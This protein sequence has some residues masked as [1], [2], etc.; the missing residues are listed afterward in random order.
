MNL[1]R[2]PLEFPASAAALLHSCCVVCI[3]CRLTECFDAVSQVLAGL[4]TGKQAYKDCL[5]NGGGKAGCRHT[6]KGY[7]TVN[8]GRDRMACIHSPNGAG[9]C[10]PGGKSGYN[11]S[12]QVW[13]SASLLPVSLPRERSPALPLLL[14]AATLQFLASTA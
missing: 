7:V 6:K 2:L 13:A 3:Y 12:I 4:A 14:L 1:D 8:Q 9:I 10:W 11:K 5:K